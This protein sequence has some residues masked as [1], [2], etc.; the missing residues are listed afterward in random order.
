MT[1]PRFLRVLQLR[2]GGEISLTI[3]ARAADLSGPDA[4]FCLALIDLFDQYQAGS[5]TKEAGNV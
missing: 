4:A 2:S 1:R 5:E 3:E